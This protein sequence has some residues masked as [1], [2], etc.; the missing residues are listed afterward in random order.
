MQEDII[1]KLSLAGGSLLIFAV[2]IILLLLLTVFESILAG[3][4]TRTERL[5]TL[6]LLVLPAAVGAILG[7]ISLRRKEGQ[8]WMAS[9][10]LVLNLLFAFFHLMIVLFAG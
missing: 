3:V 2:S 5:I 9:V 1:V 10:G 8:A 4:S 6:L 7:A